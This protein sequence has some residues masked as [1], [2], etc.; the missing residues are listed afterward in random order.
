[1]V[2]IQTDTR[3]PKGS[4]SWDTVIK[5]GHTYVRYRKKYP[6]MKNHK[7]FTG[8]TKAEV[9]RKVKQYEA[10][11]KE[12]KILSVPISISESKNVKT[13]GQ[14]AKLMLERIR[15]SEKPGNYNTLYST[16]ENYIVPYNISEIN[17]NNIRRDDFEAYFNILASKYSLST[18][19]KART[20]I[21]RV[22]DY[23]KMPSLI[24]DIKLPKNENCAVQ[25]KE[26]DFL[27]IEEAELFYEACYHQK[28]PGENTA[29][30]IGDYVYGN[31]A[32]FLI[33]V[34]YTGLRI[35][36]L[37]ALTW[38]DWDRKAN[39]LSVT[40]TKNRIKNRST[41]QYEW[42]VTPPKYPSSNR[43][44][45]V[46]ERARKSLE[47][48]YINSSY[49]KPK[50]Y[51]VLTKNGLPPSQSDITRTLQAVMCRADIFRKGFGVHDLRHSYG[52]MILEKGYETG[53][54]VDIKIIS[55]LLGHK[56]VST[57]ANIYLHVLQKHKASIIHSILNE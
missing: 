37:Y 15:L 14:A 46:P 53:K 52:S 8:R 5:K 9:T 23:Y 26:A 22:F 18:I 35:G 16:Y 31:N 49:K 48:I 55:E 56:D 40:K 17:L 10:D 12:G 33:I 2:N 29:V 54:P 11:I 50:D 28:E 43:I 42:V 57:T 6:G 3:K 51:I 25:K 45:P 47:Y 34:L 41:G 4:G 7:E 20:F 24:A 19:K 27:N 36:E 21:N 1:M 39:T 13:F 30:S 44:I 38:D 32:H